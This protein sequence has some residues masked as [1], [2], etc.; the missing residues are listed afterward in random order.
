MKIRV[1]HVLPNPDQPR[2]VFD[3]AELEGLAQSIIENTLIQPIV[4][5]QAGDRYILVDGERRWRA[6]QMAGFAEIEAVVMVSASSNHNGLERLTRALVANIQRS[7]MGPVDEARAYQRL[8]NE[9]GTLDAVAKKVGVSI[10]TV[11][12]RLS[13]LEFPEA[14]QRLF[15]LKRLTVDGTVIAA[16]KRLKSDQQIRLATMGA[17]RG[18][19][20]SAMVRLVSREQKGTPA[21]V[22]KKR[23]PKEAVK[24]AGKFDALAMVNRKLPE[25]IRRAALTTCKA[26]SLYEEA[27]SIIC[28]Q[29]PLPEFL[30]RLEVT[31]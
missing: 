23:G 17:T 6:H 20:A 12:L 21:Y 19:S 31:K 5:E 7:A 18:W 26:C 11:S 30:V 4:V 14:V 1:E 27:S 28:K 8:V 9:H 29:C 24:L 16:L 15:N 13:L 2:T 10:A 3:Q 25:P 22:T